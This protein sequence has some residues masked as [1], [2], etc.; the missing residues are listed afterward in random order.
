V[1]DFSKIDPSHFIENDSFYKTNWIK[2]NFAYDYF[3]LYDPKVLY[4]DR[5]TYID[6]V[7]K[8]SEITNIMPSIISK[9]PEI[10]TFKDVESFIL[11]FDKI[12]DMMKNDRLDSLF[13]GKD[14]IFDKTEKIFSDLEILEDVCSKAEADVLKLVYASK[15][16]VIHHYCKNYRVRN[17]CD[18]G[19]SIVE[20]RAVGAPGYG[21]QLNI[22][23]LI[24]KM[25][26]SRLSYSSVSSNT[27]FA[28]GGERYAIDG[29]CSVE[30]YVNNIKIYKECDIYNQCIEE[31]IKVY[32]IKNIMAN[33][34]NILYRKNFDLCNSM[35]MVKHNNHKFFIHKHTDSGVSIFTERD[36]LDD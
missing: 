27:S 29:Y 22:P 3:Y 26:S 34:L 20:Y 25:K 2:R 24:K 14:F 35:S 21:H 36:F 15:E 32:D 28:L 9:F 12:A 23:G 8:L 13:G 5:D 30:N 4:E 16:R 31:Y 19:S 18:I 17:V 6:R 11:N 1:K 10:T 7:K 33:I